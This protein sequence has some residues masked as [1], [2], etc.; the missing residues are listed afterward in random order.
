MDDWERRYLTKLLVF[1][2]APWDTDPYT[3]VTSSSWSEGWA[4]SE[5][6]AE[7]A[8]FEISVSWKN[9]HTGLTD[10]RDLRNEECAEFLRSLP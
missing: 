5:Y 3:A 4:Y 1:C 10:Y 6:T 7:N 8:A 2:G 9:P